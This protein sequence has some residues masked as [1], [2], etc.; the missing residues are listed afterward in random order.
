MTKK[1]FK[2][3]Y[4][5]YIAIGILL[6]TILGA[7]LGAPHVAAGGFGNYEGTLE[8]PDNTA[9]FQAF[10]N[11]ISW[12]L[13]YKL[14]ENSSWTDGR[15]YL[16]I[17]KT[18]SNTTG[19]WKFN[20]ILDVPVAVYSARFTFGV[21][22][23]VLEYI[24]RSAQYQYYLNYSGYS[25]YFDWSDMATIP[26]IQF[27]HGIYQDKFYFRFER[28][29]IQPG[30][31]EFD[32][33]FG[34]QGGRDTSNDLDDHIFAS[35]FT[36]IANCSQDFYDCENLTYNA[37]NITV[38]MIV[39]TTPDPCTCGI[40]DSAGNLIAQTEVRT[41]PADGAWLW[42]TF[43]F[44][45]NVSLTN[46]TVYRLGIWGSNADDYQAAGFN[47]TSNG[48][49]RND[50]AWNSTTPNGTLPATFGDYIGSASYS[51]LI[52][53]NYTCVCNAGTTNT[54]NT[55]TDGCECFNIGPAT[56]VFII[57]LLMVYLVLYNPEIITILLCSIFETLIGIAVYNSDVGGYSIFL[58]LCF[59]ITGIGLTRIAKK[60]F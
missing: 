52:Y 25:A 8:I 45:T 55:T 56:V 18:F 20:L 29:N 19:T 57:W 26:G 43:N 14:N 37:D 15:Q 10:R 13:E 31:Y 23:P 11:H 24:E 6:G 40:W 28:E 47:Q 3:T 54:T 50:T 27:S 2:R 58:M 16:T 49:M 46:N 59:A 5:K 33:W 22:V 32:P 48:F 4:M 34:L 7:A 30:R 41:I 38:Q 60:V 42:Q 9:F 21:D 1:P 39:W 36:F 12:N 53:C 35:N 51:L 17:D 44:T